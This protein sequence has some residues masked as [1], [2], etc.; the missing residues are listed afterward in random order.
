[1]MRAPH[2]YF[3]SP[4]LREDVVSFAIIPIDGVTGAVVRSGVAARVDG[5][6]DRAVVNGSGMLVFL[7]LP[8]PP[9]QIEVD[10]REAGFFGPTTIVHP[11]DPP[12]VGPPD[13]HPERR[14]RVEVLLEPRPD[15][16]FPP[17]TTLVRG[18]VVRGTAPEDGA[19]IAATPQGDSGEFKA[20]S[21]GRGAF[22][23]ALRL[24]PPADFDTG[25]EVDVEI[26]LTSGPTLPKLTRTLTRKLTSGRS[27]SFRDPIDLDD[28]NEPGFFI[29]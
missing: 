2:V 21:T 3:D 27:H 16:P 4:P 20:H 19:E 28:D 25:R 10:A 12:P 22:A 23:L 6:P 24:P 13:L 18:V 1:M 5:L 14:R 29:G 11:P 9:Y 17:A 26:K 7:N 15:Y 8:D